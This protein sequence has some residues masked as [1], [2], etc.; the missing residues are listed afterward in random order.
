MRKKI[1][2]GCEA[3]GDAQSPYLT[4]YTLLATRWFQLCIHVFH[5]SDS[6]DLHDHPWDFWTLL[7]RGGYAEEVRTPGR[8]TVL[9]HPPGSLLYRP[10]EHAHRVILWTKPDGSPQRAVTLVLM[11]RRRREWGFFEKAGWTRWIEYFTSKGC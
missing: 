11:L 10:A 9:L 5:R 4:R 8:T 2:Y 7:L 6:P 3:R 1:I